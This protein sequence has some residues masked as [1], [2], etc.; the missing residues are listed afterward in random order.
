MGVQFM[1]LQPSQR[2]QILGLIRTFA[3]FSDDDDLIIGNS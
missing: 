3:Y 1:D 2:E